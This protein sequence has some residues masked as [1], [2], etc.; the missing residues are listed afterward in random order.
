MNHNERLRETIAY[1][2]CVMVD[3]GSIPTIISF[4][5]IM[6]IESIPYI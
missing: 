5:I 1:F 3:D 4:L 6:L 2:L